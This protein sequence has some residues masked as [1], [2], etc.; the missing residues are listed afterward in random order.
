M[1]NQSPIEIWRSLLCAETK[2]AQIERV[3]RQIYKTNT[4]SYAEI[5]F[6]SFCAFKC[7]HCIYPA[8][9]N[10][11]NSL[12][13]F[14]QWTEIIA[15]LHKELGMITFICS[16]RS[17]D[18]TSVEVLR[19]IRQTIPEAK[20]GIIDNGISIIPYLKD[21]K[22]IQPDWL[23]ISIDG[24]E[25]EHDIQRTK[26][27]AFKQTLE[28]VLYLKDNKIAPKVNILSCLTNI[29]RSSIIDMIGFLNKKGFKNFFIAP[30]STFKDSGP[31]E[32]LR[33]AGKDFISFI[34]ELHTALKSL[35]DA[36][37]ELNIFGA[38]YLGDIASLNNE[39]WNRFKPEYDHLAYNKT[40]GGN[41]L[42]IYYHPS[43]LNGI[44]E[45][46]VNSNGDVLLPNTMRKEQI[47]KEEIV[48]NL[49]KE[50]PRMVMK[51]L[52]EAHISYY[53]RLLSEEQCIL[54]DNR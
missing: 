48:G 13:S 39:L 1:K 54:N 33:V 2:P 38:E 49:L 37:V 42:Y 23:D 5:T 47:P 25:K 11:F 3:L 46:I 8:G 27:G 41:D 45:F 22:A 21:L 50:S 51:N 31:S 17:M 18:R 29:N 32:E 30:V 44:A 12:L 14:E 6:S 7:R 10:K 36:W 28:T 53:A 34:D 20:I 24:M 35:H 16:G 15:G 19:W 26:K 40:I 43:S 9:Y 52:Q 4:P